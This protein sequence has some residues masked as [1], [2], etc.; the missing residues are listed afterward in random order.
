MGEEVERGG[1]LTFDGGRERLVLLI[2]TREVKAVLERLLQ[3]KTD[4]GKL[5]LV[6]S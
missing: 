2:Y 5:L 6:W 3:S 4:Y 1:A